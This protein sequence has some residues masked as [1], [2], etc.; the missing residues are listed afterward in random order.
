MPLNGPLEIKKAFEQ[1]A[2]HIKTSVL[3]GA[4]TRGERLP[5]EIDLAEQFG[6]SRST[7]REA[8]RLLSS[9]GLIISTK[10][11][12]GG[13]FI[14]HPTFELITRQLTTQVNL[15]TATSEVSVAEMAELR[16]L[17]DVEASGLAA[18]R[19]T[20]EELANLEHSAQVD[21]VGSTSEELSVLNR[22]F[23]YQLVL[24]S[25]NRM[26]TLAYQPIHTVLESKVERSGLDETYHRQVKSDHLNILGK[27]REGNE[28][29]ARQAMDEHLKALSKYN[30]YTWK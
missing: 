19:R 23:H 2:D 30:T 25:K 20:D 16:T 29:G 22:G 18:R 12:S 4:L 11:P 27:V 15:L 24:A 21:L 3:T 26:L 17:L 1:T 8:L 13:H 28:V 7:I 14:A 9:E 10:G 5:S 6:V